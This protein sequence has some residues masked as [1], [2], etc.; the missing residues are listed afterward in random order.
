MPPTVIISVGGAIGMPPAAARTK[1]G[2]RVTAHL[3]AMT[4]LSTQLANTGTVSR[5]STPIAPT[6]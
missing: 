3:P 1:H 2:D 6:A 5:M 4:W